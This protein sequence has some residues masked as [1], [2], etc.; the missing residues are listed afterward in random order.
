MS[1]IATTTVTV[2]RGTTTD[3]YGDEIERNLVVATGQ[4][5][6]ILEV[7]LI[8]STRKA[9]ER[10]E[11]IRRYTGRFYGS[12]DLQDGDRLRDERTNRIYLIDQ[13]TKPVNPIGHRFTRLD[14]RRVT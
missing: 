4:M 9:D 12:T 2:L 10:L 1:F 7:S 5:A 3:D 11:T 6:S 13:V 8:S 14:L